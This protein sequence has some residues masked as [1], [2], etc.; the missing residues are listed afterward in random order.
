MGERLD[1]YRR[2]AEEPNRFKENG[3][4][5]FERFAELYPMAYEA[6]A[7]STSVKELV[8][9]AISVVKDCEDCMTYHLIR[10]RELGASNDELYELFALTLVVGGSTVIPALRRCGACI[11]EL[12]RDLQTGD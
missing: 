12:E 10:L 9:L 8:A 3:N 5:V 4:A 2:L 7:L 6:G 11:D 1:A